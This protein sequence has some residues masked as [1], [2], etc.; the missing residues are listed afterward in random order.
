M[1]PNQSLQQTGRPL[2]GRLHQPGTMS[3]VQRT[4]VAGPQLSSTVRPLRMTVNEPILDDVPCVVCAFSLRG[5]PNRGRCPE[6]GKPIRSSTRSSRLSVRRVNWWDRAIQSVAVVAGCASPAV[7]FLGW[8]L[9]NQL[10]LRLC[11]GI[12]FLGFHTGGLGLWFSSFVRHSWLV[13]WGM[14]AAFISGTVAVF[15]TV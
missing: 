6:C 13:R 5:L 10:V 2:R 3:S 14:L 7:L 8:A 1:P 15:L 12:A 11:I 4:G 9:N